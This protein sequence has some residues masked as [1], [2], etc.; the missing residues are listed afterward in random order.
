MSVV[1]V[2]SPLRPA[3]GRRPR[4]RHQVRVGDDLARRP[5]GGVAAVR[6]VPGVEDV[7]VRRQLSRLVDHA[8]GHRAARRPGQGGEGDQHRLVRRGGD[9]HGIRHDD[10][11][12]R[13]P[14]PRRV[15]GACPASAVVR[16]AGTSTHAPTDHAATAQ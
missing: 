11:G 3:G 1:S 8:G 9:V 7:T 4:C 16:F 13:V 10:V 5:Q 6:L 2:C 15:R 14:G 12:D